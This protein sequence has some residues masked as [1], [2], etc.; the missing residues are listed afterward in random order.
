MPRQIDCAQKSISV[1]NEN[2]KQ[3][4]FNSKTVGSHLFAL[5]AGTTPTLELVPVV[6]EYPDVFPEE[7]PSLPPDREVEFVIELAPGTAPISRR[8]YRMPP[9]ELV[10]LKKQLEE[11]QDKGFI[12]PS[13]SPWG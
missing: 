3:V 6:C 5:K 10:D 9:N 4:V 8:P 7:L 2:D 11:L 13:S 1:T 12:R